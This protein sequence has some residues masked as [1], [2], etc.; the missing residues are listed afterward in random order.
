MIDQLRQHIQASL[1]EVTPQNAAKI[2]NAIQDDIGYK[3]IEDH[4]IKMMIND[5]ITASACIV[6]VEGML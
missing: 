2:Y 1:R 5:N 3:N 4:I 6:H